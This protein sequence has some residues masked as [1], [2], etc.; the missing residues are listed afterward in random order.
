MSNSNG[1][2]GAKV[3][4]SIHLTAA[5]SITIKPVH[6]LWSDRIALGTLCLIGGR[7]SVGKSLVAYTLTAQ[8]T[9]GELPGV[10]EG[11]PRAVVVAA[12]EDSWE[13]T[14]V[15]RLMAAGADLTR[16]FRIDVVTPE[17]TPSQ[18]DLP[19]DLSELRRIVVDSQAALILLDPLLSRLSGD[20]DTHKD[21]DVRQALEPLVAVADVTGAS[22][23]GLIHVNKSQSTDPLTMLMGSR[24]FAAVA[25]SVLFVMVDADDKAKRLIGQ[26]K[27]N[28]GRVDLPTL[29]FA[30]VSTPVAETA[31]G[32]VWTSR[33][34]WLGDSPISITDAIIASAGRAEER[35]AQKEAE[36]WLSDYLDQHQGSVESKK[37]K[38][39]GRAAG[40]TV[41]TIQRARLALNI[42]SVD[43][44]FPRTTIWKRPVE[45]PPVD[46]TF[47]V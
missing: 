2:N 28:L 43:I 42:L 12:A 39:A 17:G 25:R 23:I 41:I 38:N 10:Y 7:E 20:L 24:A 13:H 33:V 44:G 9:R 37:A 14:I 27:N 30:I 5:A 36:E 32:T 18:L 31:S 16:V 3:L 22:I 45:S 15:P 8:I 47:I 4:R 6:W 11:Q 19:I 1:K 35:S 40:H 21:A 26:A 46:T 29:S 34:N